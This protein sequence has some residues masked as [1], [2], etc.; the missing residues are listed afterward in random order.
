MLKL[1]QEGPESADLVFGSA[2]HSA[3]NATLTGEDGEAV[4]NA[5]WGPYESKDLTFTRFK[6]EGL[7][8][9]GEKL[10][11]R[12]AKKY[13]D[14]F[15]LEKGEI[16]L[17]SQFNGVRLEG[18]MDFYGTLDGKK[19]LLDYKTAAYNYSR[20]KQYTALQ[21]N[22]YTYLA[23]QNGYPA[24]EQIGYVVL[25]KGGCTIQEPLVWKFDEEEMK[26][27]LT[28]MTELCKVFNTLSYYPRNPN[29]MR[30]NYN[31]YGKASK[32]E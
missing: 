6:Y 28:E 2:I 17:Y 4:F 32:N 27:H 21:L 30:H 16:R 26:K 5:Y 20:D 10:T 9:I 13:S 24:P 12:F 18:T 19:S 8:D 22:L 15:K 23:I 25:N 31:C 29:A 3:L 14:R 1:K 11:S 7:K